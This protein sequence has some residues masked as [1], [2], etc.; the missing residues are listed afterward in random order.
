M[1]SKL[2][3]YSISLLALTALALPQGQSPSDTSAQQQQVLH[4]A[5]TVLATLQGQTPNDIRA[6]QALASNGILSGNTRLTSENSLLIAILGR[7]PQLAQDLSAALNQANIPAPVATATA[8]PAPN[9]TPT[10]TPTPVTPP[11][12]DPATLK[13]QC[14]LLQAILNRVTNVQQNRKPFARL[15]DGYASFFYTTSKY[16]Q[17][18]LGCPGKSSDV[19]KSFND[20]DAEIQVV[21]RQVADK[22]KEFRSPNDGRNNNNDV[23]INQ[24]AE[25]IDDGA[26]RL[27]A[28]IN[29][30]R[31]SLQCSK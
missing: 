5:A 12:Q 26:T 25:V 11:S 22:A 29:N 20:L 15:P 31:T 1:R 28:S 19:C 14:N 23:S 27:L 10:P 24:I 16:I 21:G 7:V 3:L 17:T 30:I 2:P 18:E 13:K 6:L 8:T 4:D 9:S